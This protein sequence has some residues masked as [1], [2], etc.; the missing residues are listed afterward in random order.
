MSVLFS[1]YDNELTVHHSIDAS[2]TIAST[3]FHQHDM[4]EIFYL[5]SGKGTFR[6][7]DNEYDLLPSTILVLRPEERHKSNPTAEEPYDRISIHFSRSIID[8]ITYGESLLSCFLDRQKGKSNLLFI[9]DNVSDYIS[10]CMNRMIDPENSNEI[11]RLAIYS[12]LVSVL[13]TINDKQAT[14]ILKQRIKSEFNQS[15]TD[16]INY[17]DE[18][19][20]ENIDLDSVADKF[21]TSKSSLNRNFRM[22]TGTTVWNYVIDKRLL[23]ARS[24]IESGSSMQ[25][26][27]TLCGFTDYSSFYRRYKNKYNESPKQSQT[28]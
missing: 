1:Y 18:N 12:G 24:L 7:E 16:I 4:F 21:F 13:Y 10:F 6:V 26:A 5:I 19:I 27:C 28:R 17:I 23:I 9:K 11:R 25:R 15:I 3:Y 2:N 22:V 14:Q 20:T 8:N